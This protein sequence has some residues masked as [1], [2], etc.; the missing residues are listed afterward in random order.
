MFD[1]YECTNDSFV[2]LMFI[3]GLKHAGESCWGA[4]E[5][6]STEGPCDYCGTG[7]CCR[8]GKNYQNLGCDGSFGGDNGHQCSEP[9]DAPSPDRKEH[10]FHA[11]DDVS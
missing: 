2:N 10:I 6:A 7:M 4:N 5:C 11:H 8:K 1:V 9:D 3:G